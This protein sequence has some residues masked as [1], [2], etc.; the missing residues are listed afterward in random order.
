MVHGQE[1]IESTLHRHLV[2]HL[3]A[4]IVLGTI[5]D[6][7]VAMNWIKSTYLYVRALKNPKHYGIPAGLSSKE[8]EAR[9]QGKERLRF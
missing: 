1:L 3:N 5:T 8:V 9:L 7:A 4:E 6:I 2:E